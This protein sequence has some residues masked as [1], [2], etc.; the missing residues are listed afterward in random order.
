MNIDVLTKRFLHGKQINRLRAS[1]FGPEK[2]GRRSGKDN[3]RHS[4]TCRNPPNRRSSHFALSAHGLSV[5]PNGKIISG[6]LSFVLI[7]W[8]GVTECESVEN[9]DF[10]GI[11]GNAVRQ[12]CARFLHFAGERACCTI[13]TKTLRVSAASRTSCGKAMPALL[14]DRGL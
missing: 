7:R 8:T 2:A 13:S 10:L 6:E 11:L 4:M 12:L 9:R 1:E 14:C 3:P 5:I